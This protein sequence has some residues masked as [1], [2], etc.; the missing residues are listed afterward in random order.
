MIV[1]TIAL[2]LLF[3]VAILVLSGL[4]GMTN[5]HGSG[6]FEFLLVIAVCLGMFYGFANI[7]HW[8]VADIDVV[9]KYI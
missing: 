8:L 9:G 5:T 1:L 2:I 6:L 3:L 4:S 7:V